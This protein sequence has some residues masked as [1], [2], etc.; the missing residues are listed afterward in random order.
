MAVTKGKNGQWFSTLTN[1]SYTSFEAAKKYDSDMAMHLAGPTPGEKMLEKMTTQQVKDL[2]TTF[3][4]QSEE[5]SYRQQ[6]DEAVNAWFNAN[7]QVISTG[8]EGIANRASLGSWLKT[9]HKMPPYSIYDLENA[10][11]ALQD[12]G[13]LYEIPTENLPH[14][15]QDKEPLNFLDAQVRNQRKV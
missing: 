2:A 11:L 7:Q 5:L 8:A 9:N 4:K 3:I 12:L 10:Y 14:P 15:P 6:N 13:I 1:S